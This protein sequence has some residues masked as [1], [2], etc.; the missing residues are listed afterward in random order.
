MRTLTLTALASA[1]ALSAA[2][3][4]AQGYGHSSHSS[5]AHASYSHGHSQSHGHTSYSYSPSTSHGHVASHAYAYKA[6]TYHAPAYHAPAY[7][8]PVYHAPKVVYVAPTPTTTYETKPAYVL[9]KVAGHC[10]EKVT[11]Y[12]YGHTSR[13]TVECKANE[14]EKQIEVVPTPIEPIEPPK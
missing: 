14:V 4:F 11:T 5:H 12:G 7:V 9:Q 10:K 3:A 13:Q 6:P 1:L 2:P 8:A